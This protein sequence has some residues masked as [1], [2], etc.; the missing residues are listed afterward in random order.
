[1]G[2]SEGFDPDEVAV[3]WMCT[4][5][6]LPFYLTAFDSSRRHLNFRDRAPTLR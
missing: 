5:A 4:Q 2:L 1:M 3:Q 6:A